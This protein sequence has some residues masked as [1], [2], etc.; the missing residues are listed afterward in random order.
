[1]GH[2]SEFNNVELGTL[3]CAS[4]RSRSTGL[5]T[6]PLIKGKH[7]LMTPLGTGLDSMAFP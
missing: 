6:Q 7:G 1:L 3:G 5:T 4:V 2:D